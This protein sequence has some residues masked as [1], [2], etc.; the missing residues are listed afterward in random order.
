MECKSTTADSPVSEPLEVS[1]GPAA[2]DETAGPTGNSWPEDP[3]TVDCPQKSERLV[4]LA[5]KRLTV[6]PPISE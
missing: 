2:G 1:T 5:E 4:G 3:R 6:D